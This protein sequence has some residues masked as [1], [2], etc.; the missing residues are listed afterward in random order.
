M[1]M[2]LEYPSRQDFTETHVNSQNINFFSIVTRVRKNSRAD[3][4]KF[5][6]RSMKTFKEVAALTFVWV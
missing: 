4:E 6:L 3:T 2:F 5:V 1:N